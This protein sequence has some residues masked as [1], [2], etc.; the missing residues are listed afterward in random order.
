[1]RKGKSKWQTHE[2]ERTEGR[3]GAESAALKF[4]N[5]EGGESGYVV[6]PNLTPQSSKVRNGMS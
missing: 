5:K 4:P 2:D 3:T 6:A 1:M